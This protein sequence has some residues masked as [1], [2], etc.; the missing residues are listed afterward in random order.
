MILFQKT[1]SM[2]V[3]SPKY[4]DAKCHRSPDSDWA[5]SSLH[6]FYPQCYCCMIRLVLEYFF[7][8]FSS[9]AAAVLRVGWRWC[10]SEIWKGSWEEVRQTRACQLWRFS[11]HIWKE[12][13]IGGLCETDRAPSW[14]SSERRTACSLTAQR[15]G[16]PQWEPLCCS[17]CTVQFGRCL[18]GLALEA[19]SESCGEPRVIPPSVMCM[20][21][22]YTPTTITLP[23]LRWTSR[24][25]RVRLWY[26][27]YTFSPFSL[28]A[29][30]KCLWEILL[31]SSCGKKWAKNRT[32][33]ELRLTNSWLSP[34]CNVTSCHL[35]M[36]T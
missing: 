31:K 24:L 26:G 28:S 30:P 32:S 17:P 6:H 7:S 27:F 36:N 15:Q 21:A 19:Q 12:L 11:S 33:G 1:N 13:V 29:G 4:H 25:P 5:F 2:V 23:L 34:S 10:K 20:L 16:L 14:L 8:N 9:L 18:F 3:P 22:N 35:A